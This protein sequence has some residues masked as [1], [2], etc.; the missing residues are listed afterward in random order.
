MNEIYDGYTFDL[1][2]EMYSDS[3]EPPQLIACNNSKERANHWCDT[4]PDCPDPKLTIDSPDWIKV[5][6]A[7]ADFIRAFTSGAES[8]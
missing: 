3:M 7:A 8:A 1:F 2:V 6:E 5:R 4:T